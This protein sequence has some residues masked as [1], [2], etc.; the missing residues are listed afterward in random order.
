MDKDGNGK[1]AMTRVVVRP[2]IKFY[3]G[4]PPTLEQREKMQHQSQE[5]WFFSN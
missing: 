1:I 5:L 4:R 3:G 2:P